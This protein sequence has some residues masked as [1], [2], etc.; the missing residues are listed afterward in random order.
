MKTVIL[1]FMAILI[2]GSCS[3][4]DENLIPA[5]IQTRILGHVTSINGENLSDVEIKIGEYV[6]TTNGGCYK[7]KN[8]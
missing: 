6:E 1:T 8:S 5:G 3:K 2:F 4:D 7:T